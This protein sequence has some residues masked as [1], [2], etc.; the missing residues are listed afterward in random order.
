MRAGQLSWWWYRMTRPRP[1]QGVA[2]PKIKINLIF[3]GFA[4]LLLAVAVF[5]LWA[6]SRMRP[7][8]ERLAGAKAHYLAS[9]AIN[10][11]VAESIAR[12][13]I[14]YDD[15]IHFEKDDTGRITALKT[16]MVMAN[17]VK[18]DIHSATLEKVEQLSSTSVKIPIGNLTDID[19]LFGRGPNISVRLVPVGIVDVTFSN[20]FSAEGINQT[21]HQILMTINTEI[22]VLMPGVTATQNISI[23]VCIA[24][25]VIVGAVPDAYAELNK[26]P[27]FQ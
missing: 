14:T 9:Q 3:I 5:A 17:R 24:E 16:D 10:Q 21:L 15:L 20:E 1:K 25:T 19:L 4:V 18:N 23:Q 7:Q 27:T 13:E 26:N 22:G 11:A 12:M 2:L 6:Q 8:V